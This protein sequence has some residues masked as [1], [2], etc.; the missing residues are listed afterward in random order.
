M[1]VIKFKK[2][3]GEIP[4]GSI[5]FFED[6]NYTRVWV[7]RHYTGLSSTEM[8]CY[9]IP[10][11]EKGE[12]TGLSEYW[13]RFQDLTELEKQQ[14]TNLEAEIKEKE[15]LYIGPGGIFVRVVGNISD[16]LK[17]KLKQDL[18]IEL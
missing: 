14:L 12:Y 7:P 4:E 10:P 18:N 8:P 16:D 15:T 9:T 5:G 17:K 6:K 1:H 13:E 2:A 3:W 11:N